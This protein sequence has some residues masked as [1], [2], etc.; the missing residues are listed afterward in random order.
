MF[1]RDFSKPRLAL[2]AAALAVVCYGL[3]MFA[4]VALSSWTEREL[5][6]FPFKEEDWLRYQLPTFFPPDGD[7]RIMLTGPSTVREN[8]RYERFEAA[9]PD[10]SIFQGGISL[11]TLSDVTA[12]LEYIEK[13]YG[14]EALPGTIIMGVAPRF[15]ADIPETR[16]FQIG[17]EKYSPYFSA[18]AT[19]TGLELVP[20]GPL[21]GALAAARFFTGKDPERIRTALIAVLNHWLYGGP[22]DG[23][24]PG[25]SARPAV[26]RML[27]NPLSALALSAAGLSRALQYDVATLFDWYLSPYKYSLNSPRIPKNLMNWLDAPDSWWSDVFSWDPR[28]DRAAATARLKRFVDFVDSRKI[29]LLVINMP[30]REMVR[31]RLNEAKYKAYLGLVRDTVGAGRFVDLRFFLRSSD[32][33]YDAEHS[34]PS[35]SLRLTREVIKY[36]R[37]VVKREPG[38]AAG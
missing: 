26:D 14:A 16:P 25:R 19:R 9:F 3:F 23:A 24:A 17:L 36:S 34:V 1:T 20:R 31:T 21:A 12:S 10:H 4:G 37:P 8:F 7:R 6:T 35:A 18:E 38:G 32:E 2:S 29:R 28:R 11:G 5:N 33:F 30:E 15:I 22:R 27:H 13:V